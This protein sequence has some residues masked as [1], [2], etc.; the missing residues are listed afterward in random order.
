MVKGPWDRVPPPMPAGSVSSNS[1]RHLESI[2]R[3]VRWLVRFKMIDAG[4]PVIA[5]I[6]A[7]F[8]L[9]RFF[10]RP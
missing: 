8:F 10:T 5:I 4:A 9:R 6:I 2:D 3:G 7:Y 1:D